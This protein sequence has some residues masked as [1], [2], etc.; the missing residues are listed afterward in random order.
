LSESQRAQ[1]AE[2][3]PAFGHDA[4]QV[5]QA[6]L[7]LRG[8]RP[9]ALAL[10]FQGRTLLDA[11]TTLASRSLSLPT[12]QAG[13]T[14]I[15]LLQSVTR[16]ILT[17]GRVRQGNR[18][19][20]PAA[21]AL[22]YLLAENSPAEYVRLLTQLVTGSGIAVLWSGQSMS[23]PLDAF[24]TENSGRPSSQRIL[25]SAS[26][27]FARDVR[28]ESQY[29]NRA[30]AHRALDGKW[31]HKG[32]SPEETLRM[33]NGVLGELFVQHSVPDVSSERLLNEVI[34]QPPKSCLLQVGWNKKDHIVVFERSD[35][36]RVYFWNPQTDDHKDGDAWTLPSGLNVR[37]EDARSGLWS[38]PRKSLV[39]HLKVVNVPKRG[40]SGASEP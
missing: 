1:L 13:L 14:H 32:L 21:A 6:L 23:S 29:S 7:E 11:L 16:D 25:E 10:D 35:A 31:A 27:D 4:A 37:V 40:G 2:V 33:A 28:T 30:D 34:S 8:S 15:E 17:L 9:L 18:S 20:C 36:D 22:G 26:M 3:L 12:E 5:G 24:T 38:S 19:V 39:E